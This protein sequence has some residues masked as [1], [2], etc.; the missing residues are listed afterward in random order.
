MVA[1]LLLLLVV[2]ALVTRRVSATSRAQ[3]TPTRSL[4][5]I[6]HSVMQSATPCSTNKF[7]ARCK[8]RPK[9]HAYALFIYSRYCSLAELCALRNLYY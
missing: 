4:N 6:R 2:V 8:Y 5:A 7:W 3:Q 1:A 9:I